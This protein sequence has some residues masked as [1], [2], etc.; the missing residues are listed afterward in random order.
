MMLRLK[1]LLF[2]LVGSLAVSAQTD[3]SGDWKFHTGDDASWAN[4]GFNDQDW[5]PILVGKYWEPQGYSGYDGY[6]WYRKHILIPSSL[7]NSSFLKESLRLTLGKIDDGDQVYLNG[8]LIGQN[9]GTTK[10][11]TQGNWELERVYTVPLGDP[12]IHWD[13]DNVIAV[14]VYDHGGDGGMFEGP[15]GLS[16]SE[17]TDALTIDHNSSNFR[18]KG[19]GEVR[20][21]IALRSTALHYVFSG[22]LTIALEDPATLTVVWQKVI[23]VATL[24][25]TTPFRYVYSIQLPAQQSYEIV[26]TFHDKRSGKEIASTEGLPYILT[27]PAPA[28]PRINGA[29][30]VGVRPHHPLIFKVPATGVQPITYAARDLP[31]GVSINAL[32][33]VITGKIKEKGTYTVH[34]TATNKLGKTN[35]D[36]QIVVGDQI[37]LTPAMGWNS[38][39]CWGLSVSD[40]KVRAAAD[41]MKRS[42]LINHGWTY[43][44]MD[45]GWERPTR[46]TDGQVVPNDKFPDMQKMTGYV[47]S[48]GLRVGIYSSPGPKTCG[49]YLGSY[50]HEEQDA[51][52]YAHWGID[53]LKYD[54]CTYSEIAPK[55][56][57]DGLKKP[58]QV[59]R[60]ALDKVDRDILFSLCQYGWGNVWEWGGALGGNSW[61]TTGDIQDTWESMSRIGFR[62]DVCAPYTRPGNWNDPDMLVVGRVGWGPS[63]HATRL[64][65]DEQYTHISLWSLLSAPL[66]IGCD[67]SQMDDFTLSLL[68]NDEVLAIDQDPLGKPAAKASVNGDIQ[69]WTKPLADGSL[70][71]GVFNLGSHSA[72]FVLSL[73]DLGVHGAQNIRD[74]WR[75]KDLGSFEGNYSLQNVP[76]HGV[77]LLKVKAGQ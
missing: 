4:P 71:V 74:C 11:I 56:D 73:T 42:G 21:N 68:S 13:Q 44:N 65:P 52:T 18:F 54:W 46:A 53:Y 38:W 26:Y 2:C 59:M 17:V 60:S 41:A 39:N 64:T 36:L 63:L 32:T 33:G 50:Q 25:P 28:T 45:D 1:L 15:Y 3:L 62:Q 7:K 72:P 67:M 76:S 47:H 16:T 49:G 19:T 70:A 20:K 35:R 37:A 61:R 24:T 57:L 69:V 55:P 31:A 51:R 75:Q 34:L 29:A 22:N 66:L 10:D 58:Y 8:K 40:A 23:P 5:K 77:V 30:V 9:A 48:L 12:A 43:I 6:A 14:R 27:P